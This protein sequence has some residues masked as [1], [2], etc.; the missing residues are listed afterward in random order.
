[1]SENP[2]CNQYVN[3]TIPKMLDIIF[4][5]LQYCI[6]LLSSANELK[7]IKTNCKHP[8]L[9]HRH[10]CHLFTSCNNDGT[11]YYSF[12]NRQYNQ[13]QRSL[14]IKPP[15]VTSSH[16][17]YEKSTIIRK[18]R[19]SCVVM[20]DAEIDIKCGIN[21]LKSVNLQNPSDAVKTARELFDKTMNSIEQTVGTSAF[22]D[23]KWT[24]FDKHKR[25]LQKI[26][27]KNIPTCISG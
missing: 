21:K 3:S 11:L 7:A 9:I 27:H 16:L 17:R 10:R 22:L 8:Q 4:L 1:M 18:K 12:T 24:S 2:Q 19:H 14:K 15:S 26:E 20:T 5:L 23:S 13:C 6:N 25:S